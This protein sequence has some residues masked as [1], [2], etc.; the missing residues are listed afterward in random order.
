MSM[1]AHWEGV[2]RDKHETQ[3]SWFRP[4]LDVSLRLIDALRLAPGTPLIDI[5]GGRATLVDDLLARGFADLTVLDIAEPALA[6]AR[7]RL[8]GAAAN[9]RW[10]VADVLEAELPPRHFGMWHDRAVFHFLSDDD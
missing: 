8:A 10:L 4:H 2:Y 1:S 9:V 5:G 7:A 3:T 6:G